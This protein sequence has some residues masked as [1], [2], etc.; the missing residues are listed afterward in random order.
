MAQMVKGVDARIM[1][2]IPVD[3]NCVGTYFFNVKHL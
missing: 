2:V 1:S 3:S